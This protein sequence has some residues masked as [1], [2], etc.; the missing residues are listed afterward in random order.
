[1]EIGVF[2]QKKIIVSVMPEQNREKIRV[3]LTTFPI[4]IT[5]YL[6]GHSSGRYGFLS[7]Q[8]QRMTV[9]HSIKGITEEL[10]RKKQKQHLFTTG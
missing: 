6:I 7:F 9:H 1:M 8:S 5:T 3:V 10:L 2:T 4:D